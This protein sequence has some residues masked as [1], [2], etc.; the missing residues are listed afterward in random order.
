[1]YIQALLQLLFIFESEIQVIDQAVNDHEHGNKE[2]SGEA[3]R[4]GRLAQRV[5]CVEYCVKDSS[6]RYEAETIGSDHWDRFGQ[7]E[8]ESRNQIRQNIFQ[9]ISVGPSKSFNFIIMVFE[10]LSYRW[11]VFWIHEN[12]KWEISI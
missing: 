7:D 6:D 1:M 12:L 8:Q 10:E 4:P 9:V 3:N 2:S 5:N 11:K